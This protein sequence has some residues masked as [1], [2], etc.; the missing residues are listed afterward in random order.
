MGYSEVDPKIEELVWFL[1]LGQKEGT[2][3]NVNTTATKGQGSLGS[4]RP[5]NIS[6]EF[7]YIICQR[8]DIW[9]FILSLT[10]YRGLVVRLPS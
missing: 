2:H 3:K 9:K 1:Y 4:S 8:V 6:V 10:G 7:S 5:Q